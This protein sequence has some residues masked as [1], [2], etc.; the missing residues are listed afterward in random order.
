MAGP[1]GRMFGHPSFILLP[2]LFFLM[3]IFGLG[4]E[5][6]S[7]VFRNRKLTYKVEELEGTVE[8]LRTALD[9]IDPRQPVSSIAIQE[10]RR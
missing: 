6:L 2:V 4:F 5:L 9:E 8:R 1:E 10:D 3:A 7:L